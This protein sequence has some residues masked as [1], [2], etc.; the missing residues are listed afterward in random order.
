VSTAIGASDD[1]SLEREWWLRTASFLLRP[2]ALFEGLR[3]DSD[4]AAA[5]RQ[6]PITAIVILAG[7]AAVL[8]TGAASHLLDDPPFDGLLIAVWAFL[9]GAIYGIASYWIAGG[10]LYAGQKGANG[11]G[12]YRQARQ[13]LAFCSVP[14]IVWLVLVWPVRLALY[15]EDL[16]RT[17][18]G[19][20]HASRVV[21]DAMGGVFVLW[22]FGLL[23]LGV[24]T[25]YRWDLRQALVAVSIAVAVLAAFAIAA[26]VLG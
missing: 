22:S 23:V 11:T 26:A 21:F 19:D 16:F 6:E 18:G 20:G 12:S 1:R 5:A 25:V 3:D 4:E 7:I 13:L 8:A 15:G 24:R 9:A 17:G 14:L 10:F 2:R